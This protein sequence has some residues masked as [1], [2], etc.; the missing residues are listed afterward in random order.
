MNICSYGCGQ[1][2]TNQFKNG[3]FCCSVHYM[4]CKSVRYNN[5]GVNNSFFGKNH[6][7]E[8]IEKNREFNIGRKQN[9]KTIEK[10]KKISI[11]LWKK[12]GFRKKVL[13]NLNRRTI[14]M[15]EN[16]YP[17]FSQIE[18]MRYNPDKVDEKEIQIHCKNHNCKNSK[19]QDGWFTPTYSQLYERIRQIENKNGNGGS[20]F[21]CSDECKKEC[22]LYR[23]NP[24]Y[25]LNDNRDI[26][27]TESEYQTF[28]KFVLERD[29]YICQYCEE[30]ATDVHHERPQKLEPFF[31][32]DPDFAWSCCESCHYKK[33]HKD[34][35]SAGKLATKI[36]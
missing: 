3:K 1:E 27:Y 8:A 26:P 23:L 4:K 9:K 35:C 12:E 11:E 20:Y 22:P 13:K 25:V 7:L 5:S 2:A 18:E 16:K 31:S 30:K 6:S 15:I 14:K 24:N 29:K 19:E 21:Y 32:L 33:G 36:C 34:E 10:K 17:F 28:R